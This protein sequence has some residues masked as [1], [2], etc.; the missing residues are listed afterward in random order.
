MKAAGTFPGP[1]GLRVGQG[2]A[3]TWARWLSHWAALRV[4]GLA[5]RRVHAHQ[6]WHSLGPRNRPA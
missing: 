3:S 5:G 2:G 1:S 6:G 4:T